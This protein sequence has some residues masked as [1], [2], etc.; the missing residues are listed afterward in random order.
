MLHHCLHMQKLMRYSQQA[1]QHYS[2]RTGSSTQYTKHCWQVRL[3]P[4]TT[5][6][7]GRNRRL[8]DSSRGDEASRLLVQVAGE[9]DVQM[10]HVLLQP[11]CGAM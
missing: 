10:Q 5:Q 6:H 1:K 4:V 9:N 3:Q 8:A 2:S 11:Y 7:L